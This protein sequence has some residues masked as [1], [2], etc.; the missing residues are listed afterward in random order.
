MTLANVEEKREALGN[1][2]EERE[3]LVCRKTHEVL[4]IEVEGVPRFVFNQ[5]EH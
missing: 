4:R 5:V 1:K 2:W 3:N